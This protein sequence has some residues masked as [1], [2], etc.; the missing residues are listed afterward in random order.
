[1]TCRNMELDDYL[2]EKKIIS[3]PMKRKHRKEIWEQDIIPLCS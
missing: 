2:Q 1:M 3:S